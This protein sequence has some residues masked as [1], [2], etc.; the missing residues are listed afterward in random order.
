[1]RSTPTLLFL[2]AAVTAA[3]LSGCVYGPR[4]FG[5]PPPAYACDGY[6]AY[7]NDAVGGYGYDALGG[8]G[9][10]VDDGQFHSR[11]DLRRMRRDARLGRHDRHPRGRGNTFNGLPVVAAYIVPMEMMGDSYGMC[12]GWECCEGMPCGEGYPC[13]DCGPCSGGACEV[14]AYSGGLDVYP[15]GMS[16]PDG[17]HY[18]DG[19]HWESAPSEAYPPSYSPAP[20]EWEG[21]ML[22]PVPVPPAEEGPWSPPGES[23]SVPRTSP[24]PEDG[25]SVEGARWLPSRLP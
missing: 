11:R 4:H 9:E 19:T 7:G 22:S 18:P 8:Y 25:V 5:P 12:G 24:E 21:Q 10:C 17:M 1:M 20:G 2:L 16:Y 13:G 14:G 23:P 15:D 6:Q 3:G